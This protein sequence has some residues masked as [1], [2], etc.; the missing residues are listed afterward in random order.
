MFL[1]KKYCIYIYSY[2]YNIFFN[3][4]FLTN[5]YKSRIQYLLI[6]LVY[7]LNTNFLMLSSSLKIDSRMLDNLRKYNKSAIKNN[8]YY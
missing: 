8:L 7:F 4:L 1:L 6:Y 3:I 5:F 2:L